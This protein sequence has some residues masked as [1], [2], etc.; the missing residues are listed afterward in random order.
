M[1]EVKK[2][3]GRIVS[4]DE[5]RIREAINRASAEVGVVDEPLVEKIVEKVKSL[6]EKKCLDVEQIQ[7]AVERELMKSPRKD[8]AKAYIAYRHQRNL[9]REAKTKDILMSVINAEKNEVTLENS[10]MDAGTISGILQK[11]AS[12]TSRT[13]ADNY[14]ISEE[15]LAAV[16]GNYLHIHDKDYLP[17]RS[18]TCLQH[19]IERIFEN[20]YPAGGIRPVKHLRSAFEIMSL[21]LNV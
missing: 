13:F 18:L 12:E 6:A 3:D 14:L 19:P 15:S 7:D 11:I 20:G 8:V 4:F 10:N 5:N 9:A 2:R 17:T 1:R 16:K 21:S